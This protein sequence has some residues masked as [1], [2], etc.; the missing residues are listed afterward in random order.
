MTQNTNTELTN[1]SSPFSTDHFKLYRPIRNQIE[2]DFF[3]LDQLLSEDHRARTVVEFVESLDLSSLYKGIRTFKH[4]VGSPTTCPKILLSL[5]IYAYLDAVSSA[6]KIDRLCQEHIAYR[7]IAGKAP[8]NHTMLS[9]FQSQNPAVFRQILKSTLAV[10]KLEGLINDHAIAQDGMKVRANAGSSTYRKLESLERLEQEAEEY[11]RKIERE[12]KVDPGVYDNKVK[13]SR[14]RAAQDRKDRI[15]QAI[16]VYKDRK[17]KSK[18]LQIKE[19]L[20]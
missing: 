3:S 12:N 19:R 4:D 6:R 18:T 13:A 2:M 11:L 14:K 8:I 20:D 15:S 9:E 16:E 1:N 10:M 7:W 17:K 5:W